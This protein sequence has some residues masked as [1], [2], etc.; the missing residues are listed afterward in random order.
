MRT[1]KGSFF[2]VRKRLMTFKLL[3]D[4]PHAMGAKLA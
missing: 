1:V 4:N 3:L 2:I